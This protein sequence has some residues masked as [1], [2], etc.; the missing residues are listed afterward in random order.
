[1]ARD[2]I[3]LSDLL[4]R[5]ITGIRMFLLQ[6]EGSDDRV[7]TATPENWAWLW[8]QLRATEGTDEEFDRSVFPSG[9]WATLQRIEQM[10]DECAKPRERAR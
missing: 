9:K 6:T 2:G 10:L 7:N 1:M 5:T 3:Y 4:P 8:F